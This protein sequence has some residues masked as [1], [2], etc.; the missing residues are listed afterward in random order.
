M[1]NS[2]ERLP[3]PSLAVALEQ[4]FSFGVHSLWWSIINF[5]REARNPYKLSIGFTKTTAQSLGIVL[6]QFLPFSK[7]ISYK[8]FCS[9]Y[10]NFCHEFILNLW[11]NAAN[12]LAKTAFHYRIPYLLWINLVDI[13]IFRSSVYCSRFRFFHNGIN[14]FNNT[15]L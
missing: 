7:K 4:G 10:M 11:S 12:T 15:L 5:S 8:F 13:N 2:F 14:T 1:K 6:L 9:F 3:E